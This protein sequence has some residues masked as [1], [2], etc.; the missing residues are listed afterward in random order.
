[1][2]GVPGGALEGGWGLLLPWLPAH[3]G[4]TLLRKVGPSQK[5]PRLTL[6]ALGRKQSKLG[7]FIVVWGVDMGAAEAQTTLRASVSPS[8]S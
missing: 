6:W 7:G 2:S 3:E 1:M 8:L 4:S 5:R